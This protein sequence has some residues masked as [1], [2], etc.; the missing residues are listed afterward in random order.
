M[1]VLGIA[2]PFGHD[3]S[4]ALL[5]DGKVIAAVEEERFTRKKHA[6]GQLPVNSVK[7]CLKTAGLKPNEIDYVAFP[8]SIKALRQHRWQYLQRTL[9]TRPSR[10]FK[11][12][13]RNERELAGE[14]RFIGDTLQQCGFDPDKVN[15]K[16]VEHHIAHAASAFFFSG[17]KEA[18]V[19]SLDAG[20]ELASTLLG[21]ASGKEITKIKEILAPD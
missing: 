7:Y 10:A 18:A 19:L 13:F 4:A 17:M 16:W 9:W 2:A 12:F 8:W 3:H 11:K 1:R 20:G 21:K 14:K 5:V 6:D 15:L